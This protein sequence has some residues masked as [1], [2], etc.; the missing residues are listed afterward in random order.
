MMLYGCAGTIAYR[1]ASVADSDIDLNPEPLLAPHRAYLL[2]LQ[3]KKRPYL[4]PDRTAGNTPADRNTSLTTAAPPGNGHCR[5][6]RSGHWADSVRY[7]QHPLAYE[8]FVATVARCYE[9]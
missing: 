7:G 4:R 2:E 1:P 6:L 8:N 9:N 3:A 5:T